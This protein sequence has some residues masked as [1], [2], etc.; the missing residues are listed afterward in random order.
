MLTD[1]FH[2]KNDFGELVS[3]KE[4]N[5]TY[6]KDSRRFKRVEGFVANQ[7]WTIYAIGAGELDNMLSSFEA[8]RDR[9]W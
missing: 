2:K 7:R 9:E 8:A 4:T 6:T 3:L 1:V 5:F